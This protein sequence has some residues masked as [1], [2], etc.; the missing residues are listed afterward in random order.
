MIF[1]IWLPHRRLGW[2]LMCWLFSQPPGYVL[3]KQTKSELIGTHGFLHKRSSGLKWNGMLL[4]EQGMFVSL[5]SFNTLPREAK[6]KFINHF[7]G[8][9]KYSLNLTWTALQYSSKTRLYKAWMQRSEENDLRLVVEHQ[10][11][12]LLMNWVTCFLTRRQPF[13]QFRWRP[14]PRK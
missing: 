7:Q 13:G 12:T 2:T 14:E 10:I 8:F 9:W 6:H 11:K 5:F 4:K 1:N 3:I